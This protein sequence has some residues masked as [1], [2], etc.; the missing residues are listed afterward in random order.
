MRI[1]IFHNHEKQSFKAAQKLKK[2]LLQF[3][4][5]LDKNN[6]DVVL[7]VG[8]DG[9]LLSA[10]HKYEKYLD[11]IQFVG[12]HIGHLGFYTDWREFEI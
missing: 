3:S 12:I 11:K 5:V 8:G 6:P 10:F 2:L 4:F 9:T 7:S 1:A